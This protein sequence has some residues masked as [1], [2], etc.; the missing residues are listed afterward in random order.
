MKAVRRDILKLFQTFAAKCED[1][2]LII[3]EYLQAF[4]A[5][6]DD[7]DNSHPDSRDPQVIMLFASLIR[8][9]GPQVGHIV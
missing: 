4:S 8:K 5:L 1:P 6:I 2:G 3:N 7:Y 9:Y